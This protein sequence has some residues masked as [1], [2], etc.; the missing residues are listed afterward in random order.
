M[1]LWNRFEKLMGSDTVRLTAT[2]LNVRDDHFDAELS[3]GT[4]VVVQ[5]Q[6]TVGNTYFIVRDGL[7]GWRTD[8]DAPALELL[9]IEV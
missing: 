4:V 3:G 2:C 7:G 8:G 6:G 9:Q 1:N 5:G